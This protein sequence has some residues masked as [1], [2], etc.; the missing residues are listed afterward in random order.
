MI[1][2]LNEIMVQQNLR[3][4]DSNKRGRIKYYGTYVSSEAMEYKIL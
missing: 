3:L 2:T 4:Q 1:K